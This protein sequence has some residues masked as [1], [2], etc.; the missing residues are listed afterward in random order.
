MCVRER[1]TAC[2]LSA[3]RLQMLLCVGSLYASCSTTLWSL[4]VPASQELCTEGVCRTMLS[5]SVSDLLRFPC[6]CS[7][8]SFW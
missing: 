7:F 3:F 5:L 1:V 2:L 8:A 6:L 4:R